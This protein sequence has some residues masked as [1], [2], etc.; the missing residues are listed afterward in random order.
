MPHRDPETGQFLS[1]D[2][3]SYTDIEVVSM[4]TSVGVEA[5]NLGGATGFNG[6][7][8][9][10]FEAQQLVD[11]DEIVDR[12]EELRLLYA[13]HCIVVYANSTET[14]DG[15]VSVSAEVSADPSITGVTQAAGRPQN[16]S[17]AGTDDDTVTAGVYPNSDDSIDI[18]GRVLTAVGHSP[19]S[20][21]G[22]GVGGGGSAGEDSYDSTMFPAEFGRF[23]PR[24]ELFLNGRLVAWNVDD[25]GIHVNFSGQHVYG[26]VES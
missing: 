19:F 8:V 17:S 11:Y 9:N 18:V 25:S 20:D 12:N 23:H 16:G 6:G 3:T 7:A 10:D 22:T 24:D 26:V 4:G 1:H 13:Q 21:G 5:G 2:E 15:T 14:A